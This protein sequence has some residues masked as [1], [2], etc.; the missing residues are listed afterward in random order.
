MDTLGQILEMDDDE[1]AREFSKSIVYNFFEQASATLRNIDKSMYVYSPAFPV[2]T[3]PLTS[4]W[5]HDHLEQ[6]KIS[7]PSLNLDISSRAHL[8]HLASIEYSAVVKGCNI[9]AN[10]VMKRRTSP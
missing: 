10:S 3:H 7:S 2:A 5:R 8:V 4:V 6:I 1:D 9:M